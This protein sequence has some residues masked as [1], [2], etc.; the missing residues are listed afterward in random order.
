MKH[1]L[2]NTSVSVTLVLLALIS[3]GQIKKEPSMQTY[4]EL[5]SK[6]TSNTTYQPGRKRRISLT[7]HYCLCCISVGRNIMMSGI[8][9]F[10]I[11]F[12]S[13]E[14]Q[15]KENNSI[16]NSGSCSIIDPCSPLDL[17]FLTVI[18]LMLLKG[19]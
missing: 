13:L 7:I 19:N 11:L 12:K 18:A 1:A 16:T 5:A 9:K 10:K 17:L 6:P 4:I 15:K 8:I 2:N 14:M 3:R